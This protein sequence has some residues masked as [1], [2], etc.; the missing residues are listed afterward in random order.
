MKAFAPLLLFQTVTAI[1]GAFINCS[2]ILLVYTNSIEQPN[3]FIAL[4]YEVRKKPES[5][6]DRKL[7]D[8]EAISLI[9]QYP[10]E[11]LTFYTLQFTIGRRTESTSFYE[12]RLKETNY[13]CN[14]EFHAVEKILETRSPE[15]R[16]ESEDIAYCEDYQLHQINSNL[17]ILSKRSF[18]KTL[19]VFGNRSCNVNGAASGILNIEMTAADEF[20]K[21]KFYR[22]KNCTMRGSLTG[23]PIKVAGYFTATFFII[24]LTGHLCYCVF[25]LVQSSPDQLP[26]IIQVRPY[27]P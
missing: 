6:S 15:L 11:G 13:Q 18:K 4:I 2:N 12:L 24:A 26:A 1:C 19:V 21:A 7:K 17:T 22:K 16:S 25:E 3:G 27:I 20:Q 10:T 9:E 23:I 5:S 14:N 8:F